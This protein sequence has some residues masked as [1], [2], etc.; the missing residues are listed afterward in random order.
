MI[1][2]RSGN[3]QKLLPIAEELLSDPDLS[4]IEIEKYDDHL[5]VFSFSYKGFCVEVGRSL[6]I[7]DK[8]GLNFKDLLVVKDKRIRNL[9]RK[10]KKLW[11]EA[12][13]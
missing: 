7:A 10:L 1:T 11:K 13:A 2:V 6:R 3:W 4:A 12:G 9:K 8:P 5:N